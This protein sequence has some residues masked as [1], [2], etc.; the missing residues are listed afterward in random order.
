MASLRFL[1]STISISFEFGKC[2]YHPLHQ[3]KVLYD[4]LNL[5]RKTYHLPNLGRHKVFSGFLRW[6]MPPWLS[7]SLEAEDGE[8]PAIYHL[9]ELESHKYSQRT[10]KNV[11]KSCGTLILHLGNLSGGTL[12]T[13]QFCEYENK[14]FHIINVLDEFKQIPVNFTKWAVANSISI[15]NVAGPRESETP[16]YKQAC[17]ILKKIFLQTVL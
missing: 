16:I 1:F 4:R 6:I 15:L 7:V 8:I 17:L 2:R 13:I 9:A 11:Q 3:K 5:T 12:K 14:P 10:L